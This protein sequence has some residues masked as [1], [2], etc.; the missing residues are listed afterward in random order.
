MNVNIYYGGRGLIDDPVLHVINKME[1]VLEELHVNVTRYNLHE[2]KK[3]ITTVPQTLKEADGVILAT[4]V[5]WIGIGGYM[6]LFLD[7]CW[8]YGDKEKISKIYMVPVVMSTTYGEREANLTLVNAWEMLGGKTCRGVCAY[9]DDAAAFE[10]NKDYNM[11]IEKHAED[12]YRSI[13]QHVK[14][15]PTSNMAIKKNIMKNKVDYTPQES[16]QLSKYASDDIY[17]KKQK[18]DIEALASIYK[19][20]LGNNDGDVIADCI[21]KLKDVFV[22]QSY[23]SGT[24]VLQIADKNKSIVIEIDGKSI[25]CTTGSKEEADLIA[26]LTYSVL[27]SVIGGRMSFQRAFMTGNMKTKGDLN[28]IRK[29]DELFVFH[30]D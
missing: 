20:M 15:L 7:A 29:L 2:M 18:E 23:Y 25:K 28:I 30:K 27:E 5:E 22:P 6:Q 14:M 19:N 17:V 1:E 4:T 13:S 8:F 11:I 21:E 16:E 12:L 3:S 26:S 9:V 10:M 24:F